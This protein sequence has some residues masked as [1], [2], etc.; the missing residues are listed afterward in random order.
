METESGIQIYVKAQ[1]LKEKLDTIPKIIFFVPSG[2]RLKYTASATALVDVNYM[3]A[4]HCQE[5]TSKE[6]WKILDI[7]DTKRGPSVKKQ[8]DDAKKTIGALQA[9][10]ELLVQNWNVNQRPLMIC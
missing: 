8:L 4:D 1:E 9:T 5:G 3:S 7:K 6:V 10:Q 2:K